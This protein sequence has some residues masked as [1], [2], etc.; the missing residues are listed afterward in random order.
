MNFFNVLRANLFAL[1]GIC[2]ISSCDNTDILGDED[3][4]SVLD[5]NQ[6]VNKWIHSTMKSKYRTILKKGS[7]IV[8]SLTSSQ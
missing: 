8:T 5:G 4:I 3:D 2:L 6:R 1:C 7:S